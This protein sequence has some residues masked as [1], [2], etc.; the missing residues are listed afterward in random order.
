T[1]TFVGREHELTQLAAVLARTR[2]LTLTGAGGVGKTRLALE[3]A[4][5]R[6]D[7]YDD[8]VLFVELDTLDDGSLV[9]GALAHAL[10][11]RA[12]RG[13]ADVDALLAELEP[14]ALLLVLDH[15]Q[16]VIGA[17]AGLVDAL[18]RGAP[19]LTV[20]ATS[21]EPLRVP[22]EVVFRVPSLG[23]PDPARE[24]EPDSLLRYEAVRL[25][26]E[27]AGAV[28]PGFALD[29]ET[30]APVARICHRLDGLPL[31]L[32]LA[33]ARV[34]A[35]TPAALADRLDDR[36]RLLRAGSRTA[37]TRQQTLEATLDWSHDLPSSDEATRLRRPAAF[38]GSFV[39]EAA[40]EACSASTFPAAQ[41][42]C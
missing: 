23:I 6:G 17:A 21:R 26:V 41:G 42:P 14:R 28:A 24:E 31:A 7:T 35:L 1:S 40:R 25:F 5:E 34:D 11:L 2:L 18:L 32:E 36:F 10:D 4:R 39:P 3:L 22:G 9:P 16:H 12:F 8:G 27:R 13:G 19:R 30:A 37:P 29:A 20:V 38:S 33:A 15:C